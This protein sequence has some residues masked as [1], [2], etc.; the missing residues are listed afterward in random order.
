[1]DSRSFCRRS[2]TL[3]AESNFQTFEGSRFSPSLYETLMKYSLFRQPTLVWLL[4]LTA[5]FGWA[6][7]PTPE[8]SPPVEVC[9]MDVVSPV[10]DNSTRDGWREYAKFVSPN[11]VSGGR[12]GGAVRIDGNYAVVGAP[13][14]VI[15]GVASGAAYVYYRG[16][17]GWVLQ[18]ILTPI[19]G[20]RNDD[21]GMSVDIRGSTIAVGAPHEE[22]SNAH[23]DAGAVYIFKRT[24]TTWAQTNKLNPAQRTKSDEFGYS[25]DLNDFGIW[26]GALTKETGDKTA[27]SCYF[28]GY[29]GTAWAEGVHIVAP[30]A[31]VGGS[32]GY[33][34]KVD[35]ANTR[36]IIGA[37]TEDA[38]GITEAGKVYVYTRANTTWTKSIE[39]YLTSALA[40]DHLG[41]SIAQQGETLVLGAPGADGDVT[42]G[43]QAYVVD[44]DSLGNWNLTAYLAATASNAGRFGQSVSIS[45]DSLLIGSPNHSSSLSLAGVAELYVKTKG[46]W[47]LSD[48]I[49]PLQAETDGQFGAS[50]ALDHGYLFVGG[51]GHAG[52]EAEAGAVF[53]FEEN[54]LLP[55]DSLLR[56]NDQVTSAI[57]LATDNCAGVVMGSTS[58]VNLFDEAGTTTQVWNFTD[59]NGNYSSAVRVV[60]VQKADL[61]LPYTENMEGESISRHCWTA[62]AEPVAGEW[63]ITE[64]AEQSLEGTSFFSVQA[65][66]T[67]YHEATLVSPKFELLAGTEYLVSFLHRTLFTA[68]ASEGLRLFL[69]DDEGQE[70]KQLL[71]DLQA[72]DLTAGT[73]L[74]FTVPADGLHSLGF[75]AWGST[76][77]PGLAIDEILIQ[78]HTVANGWPGLSGDGSDNCTAA[79]VGGLNGFARSRFLDDAGRLV[80]EIDPNGNDLGDVTIQMTDYGG[81]PTA[82]YTR[83]AVLSRHFDIVPNHGSGPYSANGGVRVRLYVDPAELG[84]F[85]GQVQQTNTWQDM[86]VLHYSDINQDCDITN[87]TGDDFSLQFLEATSDFGSEGRYLEFYTTSFSEFTPTSMASATMALPV[88]ISDL[89]AQA[90]PAGNRLEWWVDREIAFSHYEVQQSVDGA[91]F[92]TLA[93]V[94]GLDLS[95]YSFLD[96]RPLPQAYYRLKLVDLDGSTSFSNTVRVVRPG[97]ETE[98]FIGAFPVPTDGITTLTYQ[99]MADGP[100]TFRLV[101][102]AGRVLRTISSQGARGNNRQPID[103]RDLP[104]GTYYVTVLTP[105]GLQTMP[106]SRR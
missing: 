75:T 39:L 10:P 73:H 30:V 92:S 69:L 51:T 78:E 54:Y 99:L 37:P 17:N 68:S 21:F 44:R 15:N 49:T 103:L 77:A 53:F 65:S 19:E 13:G 55:V 93:T 104:P 61:T 5:R 36:L 76:S 6:S 32:F 87:S 63:T 8:R 31:H 42:G 94:R 24:G 70:V 57:P 83:G 23:S 38:G 71:E 1:M 60:T 90:L 102:P 88:V 84:Q 26:V 33:D 105:D 91:G 28:F 25:L 97:G 82:P 22:D 62:A 96:E 35:D 16:I 11:G 34:I 2:E 4:I 85:N 14:T 43:G 98:A 45:G 89:Q 18:D 48:A 58:D 9:P 101:N 52:T 7:G 79:T 3:K 64:D 27:G 40:Y 47:T 100:V 12:Y 81:V 66:A 41:V 59:G 80:A 95:H 20:Y 56:C 50:V 106:L 67:E 46:V 29:D 72:P 86:V 74:I